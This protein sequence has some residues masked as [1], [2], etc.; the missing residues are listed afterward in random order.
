[1]T[2][3]PASAGGSGGADTRKSGTAYGASAGGVATG[4]SSARTPGTAANSPASITT[5]NEQRGMCRASYL[6]DA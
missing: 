5:T 6:R 2:S 1:M 3:P 4:V